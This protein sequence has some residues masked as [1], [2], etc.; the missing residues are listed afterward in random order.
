VPHEPVGSHQPRG[1][2]VSRAFHPAGRGI[3]EPLGAV[4]QELVLDPVVVGPRRRPGRRGEPAGTPGP[5]SKSAEVLQFVAFW[6]RRTGHLPGELIFDSKLTT[7]ANLDRLNRMGV[8][9]ITLRRRSAKL[10]AAVAREPVSAWRRIEPD[11]SR[12]GRPQEMSPPQRAQLVERACL[13]PVAEGLPLTPW[14][15]ADRARQAVADGIVA[16]ISPAPVR[17]L[18]QQVDRRPHRTRYR[19]TARLDERFKERAEKGLWCYGDAR[20]LAH[21]GAGVVC[22]DEVPNLQVRER[23]PLRRALPGPIEQ[24]EFESTRHG[25]V[26]LLLFLVAHTGEM[27]LTVR[28]ANDAAHYLPA[29]RDFRRRHRGL[30]G[31]FLIP[32]G[33]ASPIAPATAAYL[34]GCTGWWRPR[35]TPAHAWWLNQ[36]EMLVKAFGGRSFKRGSWETREG[37]IKHV[38]AS[39]P[40]DNERHAHPFNWTW[41]NDRMRKGFAEHAQ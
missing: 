32:D 38:L 25:T 3:L 36:A 9:F 27:E 4:E 33:G 6:Q 37:F 41:T 23:D 30:K 34:K 16:A 12:V 14:S 7:Y 2:E 11:D 10:L 26:N 31:V 40:E 20:R 17:R 21:Q 22:T 13:G 35:L 24:Q 5:T 29:L 39:W 18:V 8:Y 28:G 1:G 19:R 15:S